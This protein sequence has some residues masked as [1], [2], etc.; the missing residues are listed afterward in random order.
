MSN[1]SD[2]N[3]ETPALWR[4]LRGLTSARIAL[5]RTGQSIPLK[6]S[7]H[8]R[9]THAHAR[10]AVYSSLD[11]NAID[12]SLRKFNLSIIHLHSQVSSREEY[13]QRPDLG[14][15]L[16][17]QSMLIGNNTEHDLSIIIA[18]GL[19]AKA[20]HDHILLLLDK[21]IPSLAHLKLSPITIVEQ[22]R[23]AI[24]DEIGSLLKSKLSLILIG[25]RPGLSSPNS[26][27]AYLTYSPTIG[28]TDESRNCVSNIRPEGLSYL[29]A[30]Q[31]ISYLIQQSLTRKISG[32]SLKD[33]SG[34]LP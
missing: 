17:D 20:I 14:R 29:E 2:Q 16:K 4:S 8:F 21:L 23:V 11:T 7:L 24:S 13:L 3:N 33:E 5:G 18:D 15:R 27:G 32:V 31:K 26:L 25:E 12:L 1:L 34:L 19:S 30:A 10:D 28:L 6:E 9:L 22:G